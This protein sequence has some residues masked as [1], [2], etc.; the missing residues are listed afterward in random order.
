MSPTPRRALL[1]SL[2]AWATAA[3]PA[4]AARA[5]GTGTGGPTPPPD[6]AIRA[7]LLSRVAEGRAAGIAVVVVEQRRV[8]QVV[9]GVADPRDSRPVDLR[10]RFELGSI[11][12]PLT[13]T[14]AAR[15]ADQGRLS[16]DDPVA[17]WVPALARRSPASAVRVQDLVTH[18][19][20]L[21]RLPNS[22]AMWWS[23]LADPA[24]PYARIGRGDLDA[25]LEGWSAPSSLPA[26]VAYSNLGYAVLGR[27]VEAAAGQP[28]AALLAE[29][30]LGPAGLERAGIARR[31]GD[32]VGTRRGRPVPSWSLG[33]FAAAGGLRADADDVARLLQALL[34]A[35]SPFAARDFHPRA[36]MRAGDAVDG[37]GNRVALGWIVRGPAGAGTV[38]HN[39][40]S[41]GFR[42]WLGFS[43]S[44]GVGV[45]VLA[46]GEES[47]D[48][49]GWQL[50]G[51]GP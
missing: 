12:K 25:W 38:W 43:P 22:V 36:A 32:A 28:Y 24:D 27:V 17:R 3:L 40:G 51:P 15:L 10:T 30:V 21:P 41:G 8:R 4:G 46:S 44:R 48:E 20:G 35:H 33:E 19:S 23:M 47:V 14:L 11:T 31:D 29:H 34:R 50:I 9:A 5:S 37:P 26:P 18:R 42:A 16:L 39:G 6:E 49:L 1:A 13:A 7:L 2:L 45:A